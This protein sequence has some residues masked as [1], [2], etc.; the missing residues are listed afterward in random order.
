MS[1]PNPLVSG[2]GFER[3]RAAGV[4]VSTGFVEL[5]ARRLNEAFASW[6]RTRRPLVTL[7]AAMSLDGQIGVAAPFSDS[8]G[9]AGREAAPREWITGEEARAQVQQMRHASDAILTGVGTAIT[10]DPQLTD[11]TSRP[12]RRALLRVVVDS[13]LRLPVT[14]KL[15]RSCHDD[16]IVFCATADMARRQALERQGVQVEQV[17]ADGQ[18]RPDVNEIIARLGEREVTS[19]L[20]EGGAMLNAAALS[21]GIVDKICLFYA[22][23][24]LKVPGAVPFASGIEL[25][26]SDALKLHN[27]SLHRFGEDF[28]VQGYLRDPYGRWS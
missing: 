8:S 7:K 27:T 21:G 18:G 9:K 2:R 13:R 20:L 10:D 16:L 11:R 6:I 23:K 3:L 19:L 14:S 25:G 22:P 17:S 12:R 4:E 24:L 15:V 28:A 5:D 1:D 26:T